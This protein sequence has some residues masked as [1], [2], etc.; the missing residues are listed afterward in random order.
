MS[1]K[2]IIT[3]RIEEGFKTMVEGRQGEI[4]SFI[5]SV[6]DPI[7]NTF[8]LKK[9]NTLLTSKHQINKVRSLTSTS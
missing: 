4:Y 7:Y 3:P 5:M 8:K 1:I 9:K 6:H 2:K